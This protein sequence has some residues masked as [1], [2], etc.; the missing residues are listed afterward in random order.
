VSADDVRYALV[1]AP[2]HRPVGDEVFV[3]TADS[4]MH[5]MRNATATALWNALVTAG[6]R[7]CAWSELVETVTTQFD[8]S[9]EEAA[10]DLAPFVARMVEAG[11]V[12]R[13]EA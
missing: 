11:L 5:W 1:G 8:V 3:L 2:L 13:V 12:Y 4:R 6:R 9:R 7:G 10:A